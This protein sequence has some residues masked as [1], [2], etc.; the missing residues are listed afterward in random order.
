MKIIQYQQKAVEELIRKIEMNISEDSKEMLLC[1]PV[2][3]GKTYISSQF[4]SKYIKKHEDKNIGFLWISPGKGSLE[5]QS[6]ESFKKYSDGESYNVLSLEDLLNQGELKGG[7]I[8]FIN[9]EAINKKDNI[10]T[11]VGEK[12]NLFDVLENSQ[13]DELIILVDESH[14][15]RNSI[16]SQELIDRFNPTVV[17]DIS[18]TPRL[19]DRAYNK[20]N[21]VNVNINDV[22]SEEFIKNQIIINEGLSQLDLESVIKAGINKRQEIEDAYRT[23]EPNCPKPLML[24]QIE[25]DSKVDTENGKIPRALFIK[26]V[27]KK[28]GVSEDKIAIWVS[29]KNICQNLDTLKDDDSEVEVLIFKTAVSTGVDIP[30]SSVLCMC[31][32]SSKSNMTLTVQT[33]GRILRTL[34]KKF[35]NDK[36]VDSAYIFTEFS[37]Y[38]YKLDLDEDLLDKVRQGKTQAF[39][40]DEFKDKYTFD[41]PVERKESSLEH[42]VDTSELRKRIDRALSQ[43]VINNYKIDESRL[44]NNL[45]S[46]E[47]ESGNIL[48]KDVFNQLQQSQVDMTDKQIKDLYLKTTRKI[49][50]QFTLTKMILSILTKHKDYSTPIDIMKLY[51]S[52]EQTFNN[53]IQ[54]GIRGYL[55]VALR[56]TKT[57]KSYSPPQDVYYS[58][59]VDSPHTKY[60]YT[61]EP[62]LNVKYSKSSSEED[63]A[64]FLN[65]NANVD[66]WYK[67]GTSG[68]DFSIIYKSSDFTN[69]LYYPDFIIID[70][71]KKLYIVDVKSAITKE[72]STDYKD[73]EVKYNEGK[74]YESMHR[75]EIIQNGFSD[76]EVSMI[77]F[78]GDTPYICKTNHYSTDFND[79]FKWSKFEI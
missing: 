57:I 68:N 56:N 29:D 51:L 12:D 65:N 40:K 71:N 38:E 31:R 61:Q 60:A 37:D 69:K 28:L 78:K 23:Y 79:D 47:I 46:G 42:K 64:T 9:W 30:R 25:N 16:K 59:I 62:D 35:Y 19:D 14:E 32:E 26:D 5:Q 72:G 20:F 73:I 24:I 8:T 53:L 13:L 27:V 58:N 76:I 66:Y 67:N 63:F 2:G 50:K 22:I 36:L 74:E 41:I 1:S 45:N 44:K 3:S 10:A 4:V 21:T 70:K 48:N 34:Y 7:D 55:E 54:E 52:H 17:C 49:N 6:S 11:R 15:S 39:L 18:A 33:L 77:K 43:E 75:Q